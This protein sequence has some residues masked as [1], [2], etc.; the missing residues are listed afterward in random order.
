MSHTVTVVEGL[1]AYFK[2]PSGPSRPGVDWAVEIAGERAGTVIVRT[3]F[4]SDPP[5]DAERKVL[6]DK[7][8]LFVQKKLEEGWIPGPGVLEA[9]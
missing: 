3:Y 7:A 9:D 8:V 1:A 5:K 6:A 4:S 2:Q